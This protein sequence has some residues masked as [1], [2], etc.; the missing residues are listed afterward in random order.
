M[1]DEVVIEEQEEEEGDQIDL[2]NPLKNKF[3]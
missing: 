3:S 2:G 1:Q